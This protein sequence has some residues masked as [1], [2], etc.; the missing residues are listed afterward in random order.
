MGGFSFLGIPKT[1]ES[2]NSL[3]ARARGLEPPPR[4]NFYR[5][6]ATSLEP[7]NINKKGFMNYPIISYKYQLQAYIY[8][9]EVFGFC[10]W[11]CNYWIGPETFMSEYGCVR[12]R[13]GIVLCGDRPSQQISRQ[14][15]GPIVSEYGYRV[16]WLAFQILVEQDTTNEFQQCWDVEFGMLGVR[17]S[18]ML[19]P[20]GIPKPPENHEMS[21]KS[22]S[23][24]IL[25]HVIGINADIDI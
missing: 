3:V 15:H 10:N 17:W 18:Q 5:P 22:T 6:W 25:L 7:W 19:A 16:F 11:V 23:R 14:S 9:V 13:V 1:Y 4:S 21:P 8:K 12:P 20:Y 24:V 2:N